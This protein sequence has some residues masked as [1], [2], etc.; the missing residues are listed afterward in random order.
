V[1]LKFLPLP[2]LNVATVDNAIIL[3]WTNA[4]YSLQ[5]A[6]NINGPYSIIPGA[7]SPFTNTSTGPSIYFRLEK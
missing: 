2:T 1:T 3:S 4:G 6:S 7:T 5:S